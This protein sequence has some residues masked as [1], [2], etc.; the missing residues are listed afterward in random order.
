MHPAVALRASPDL[1]LESVGR[2]QVPGLHSNVRR[3]VRSERFS[4]AWRV[5]PSVR[6]DSAPDHFSCP[7]CA[8]VTVIAQ[9]PDDLEIVRRRWSIQH[10][11]APGTDVV[12]IVAALGAMQ[13]QEFA[14]A[15]WSL[16][17]RLWPTTDEAMEAVFSAGDIIRTHILR[18]TWHFVARDDL[19]WMLALS[20]PRVQSFFRYY[21]KQVGLSAGDLELGHRGMRTILSDGQPRARAELGRELEAFGLMVAGGRLA[22]LM[23]HA[24]LDGVV[25]SGP[26]QGKQHTYLLLDHRVPPGPLD[27]RPRDEAVADL[28]L[29]FFQSHG[30]ATVR[31]FVWWS[32]LT[33][34]DAKAG[35]EAAG[36]ALQAAQRGKTSWY[37]PAS[38][39]DALERPAIEAGR[40]AEPVARLLG[41]YDETLVGYQDLRYVV[42]DPENGVEPFDRVLAVDGLSAGRW[43][44]TIRPFSVLLEVEL[45]GPLGAAELAAVRAEAERFG[46][47]LGLP[48]ELVIRP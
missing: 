11:L 13:A 5:E 29:R 21:Y 14:E 46:E 16:A 22:N 42:A 26:R 19:R 2:R 33:A 24:E 4:P 1:Q 44:R 48:A 12:S 25:C 10:L 7:R 43:Q 28:V 8:A 35:I 6:G 45:Y 31:D 40:D 30:P 18:P 32:G 39:F 9:L 23:M 17:Q 47:F 27:D 34:T 36:N 38:A 3:F 37:A 20:G 15:K 41:V